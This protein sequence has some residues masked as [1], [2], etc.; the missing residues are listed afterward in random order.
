MS[1][2]AW[3]RLRPK[4]VRD[5]T[6]LAAGLSLILATV[7]W[8]SRDALAGL[9]PADDLLPPW[10]R[11]VAMGLG[12]GFAFGALI[13]GLRSRNRSTAQAASTIAAQFADLRTVIDKMASQVTKIDAA[14]SGY[15][16]YGG[17]LQRMAAAEADLKTV[18]DRIKKSRHDLRNELSEGFTAGF[19]RLD[20]KIEAVRED[21]RR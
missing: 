21:L 17:I 5:V 14:I 3:F 20:Q 19:E 15:N 13:F 10:A 2:L 12:G 16:G 8:A 11:L 7:L 9:Q 4:W 18:D 6:V 1:P